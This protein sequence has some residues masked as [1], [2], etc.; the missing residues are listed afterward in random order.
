MKVAMFAGEERSFQLRYPRNWPSVAVGCFENER[1]GNLATLWELAKVGLLGAGHVRHV[2]AH[3]LAGADN[4]LAMMKARQ[5]VEEE[6]R[7][8]PLAAFQ[9]LAIEII[10]DAYAGV[11]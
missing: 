3:A 5:I 11:D 10:I 9:A 7:G 2:L 6:M 4:P 8:K 1:F